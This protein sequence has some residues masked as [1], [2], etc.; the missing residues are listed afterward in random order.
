MEREL[1]ILLS[2]SP[3]SS[4]GRSR[5]RPVKPQSWVGD[6]RLRL[7]LFS[8]DGSGWSAR[9]SF[10]VAGPRALACPFISSNGC[11]WSAGCEAASRSMAAV[12]AGVQGYRA[13]SLSR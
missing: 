11:R 5:L 9:L 10:R 1:G 2:V 7:V 4:V 3:A 6:L 8:G 13:A 12:M